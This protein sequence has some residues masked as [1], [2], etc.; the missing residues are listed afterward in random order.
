M[1]PHFILVDL[2]NIQPKALADLDRP[3][4]QV[5]VFTGANQAKVRYELAAALQQLGN[6][7][8]YVKIS[9]SGT[10][11][12]DFHIAFY[13]GELAGRHPSAT[14]QI[15]S[16]DKGFDPLIAHLAGK[17][18][19]VRRS[20]EVALAGEVPP[21]ERLATV[22]ARLRG[23]NGGRPRTLKTLSNAIAA[24]FQKQLREEEVGAMVQALERDGTIAVKDKK[25]SYA[26]S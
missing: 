11:A 18:I 15:V 16:R 5:L 13:I 19:K 6:R 8:Q 20:V 24:M 10:N 4:V 21:D 3:G 26:L 23:L 7:A 12:L 14:F 1:H 17:K 2:E 25:V 22:V 9:G